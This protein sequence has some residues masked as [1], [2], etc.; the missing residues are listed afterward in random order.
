MTDFRQVKME[1][2]EFEIV[3]Q[4]QKLTKREKLIIAAAVIG[5][6]IG[7][8]ISY[9]AGAMHEFIKIARGLEVMLDHDPTLR[10]HMWNVVKDIAINS[11]TK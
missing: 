2:P 7:G 10:E 8:A 3:E 1:V 9:R 4:K 5:G 6:G 11:T